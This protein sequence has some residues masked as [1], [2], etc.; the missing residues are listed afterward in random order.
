MVKDAMD[1][2]KASIS[3]KFDGNKKFLGADPDVLDNSEQKMKIQN[4]VKRPRI[5]NLRSKE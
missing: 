5:S 1:K 4:P 2:S 3:L